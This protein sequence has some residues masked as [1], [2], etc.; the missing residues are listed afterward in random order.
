MKTLHV[1][2][3]IN[4]Y[5]KA[6]KTHKWLMDALNLKFIKKTKGNY[7]KSWKQDWEMT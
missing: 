3:S 1:I 4:K 7:V 5:L 6:I 2:R